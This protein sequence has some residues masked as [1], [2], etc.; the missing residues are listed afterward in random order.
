M[1]LYQIFD[2]VS[3]EVTGTIMSYRLDAPAIRTFFDWLK[4]PKVGPGAHAGDFDLLCIGTQLPTG[5]VNQDPEF[6]AGVTSYPVVVAQGAAWLEA[7]SQQLSLVESE[8]K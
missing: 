6:V 5:E 8:G 4:N 1:R 7:Q 2:R 3:Q